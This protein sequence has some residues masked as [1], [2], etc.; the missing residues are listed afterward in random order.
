[1]EANDTNDYI[2][3]PSMSLKALVE[4][5]D[6]PQYRVVT[7]G[8][9]LAKSY[10]M[11]A[12]RSSHSAAAISLPIHSRVDA[13]EILM[14]AVEMFGED[15]QIVSVAMN[16]LD[17]FIALE[18]DA[19]V[20]DDFEQRSS[21]D[22]HNIPM[23][24][25]E[26][27]QGKTQYCLGMFV[28]VSLDLAIRLYSPTSGDAFRNAVQ[29]VSDNTS[30]DPSATSTTL[31]NDM[32]IMGTDS[33]STNNFDGREKSRQELFLQEVKKEFYSDKIYHSTKFNSLRRLSQH[34]N[35]Q[36]FGNAQSILMRR[37]DF[38]LCPVL[39]TTILQYMLQSIQIDLSR[40]D[41]KY[42]F[43]IGT[44]IHDYAFYQVELSSYCPSLVNIKPSIIAFS[45]ITNA[46]KVFLPDGTKSLRKK[47]STMYSHSLDLPVHSK[48]TKC[49]GR[50]L[51]HM[52]K[53]NY[54]ASI[55]SLQTNR[56]EE[57]SMTT[58][59]GK[60]SS[61]PSARVSPDTVTAVVMSL[62]QDGSDDALSPDPSM[63][64]VL[65]EGSGCLYDEQS[66]SSLKYESRS[67][68][69]Y[70][71][72]NDHHHDHGHIHNQGHATT[73][74]RSKVSM[75]ETGEYEAV[76]RYIDFVPISG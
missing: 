11:F 24:T 37:L 61:T 36:D 34:Q 6:R 56:M 67:N 63:M 2:E 58:P 32:E 76:A 38:Y 51:F 52:W 59:K 69:C 48:E 62:P 4:K 21:K 70:S 41:L 40:I 44:I 16:F 18:S 54:P 71:H 19:F 28:L 25:S 33:S 20:K 45:A 39:A 29:R 15:R 35:A 49:V 60:V 72:N 13:V 31:S 57:A 5:E 10:A 1:M 14:R 65:E 47:M 7:E 55:Q 46:M 68:Q 64:L 8:K 50:L 73:R 9:K 3:I 74:K 75:D 22:H 53:D 27:I 66:R 12:A 30:I 42:D 43:Q 23:D 17:R 26:M